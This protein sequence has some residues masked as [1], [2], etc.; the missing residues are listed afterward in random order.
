[1][2]NSNPYLHQIEN[3]LPRLLALYDENSIS[4]TLGLGDRFF[5]AWKLTD[6]G[7][8]TFQG[9]VHGL[10]RLIV[11]D[12]LPFGIDQK[13]ILERIVRMVKAIKSIQ[14]NN[15]SLSEA[16]PYESSFCVTALVAYDLL[17]AVEVLEG[18]ISSDERAE[19]LSAASPLIKF[20]LHHDEHHGLISNHL[21]TAASALYK[22]H[23]LT[24]E[25]SCDRGKVFLDRILA[26]QSDEGWYKEY[27]GADP[28]YQSLCTYYL[29]DLH[30]LRPDLGLKDSLS[31]SVRFL[32]NFAH[33]DGSFGGVY[34]SRSTRF[35]YPAGL[36]LLRDEIPEAG[37][38]ADFMRESILSRS[39]VALDTMD[40]PNLIPMFN[41]YCLAAEVFTESPKS[42]PALPCHNEELNV[43]VF[44]KAGLVVHG[45]T[46]AYTVISTNKGGVCYHFP[47]ESQRSSVK[48]MG[49]VY[50]D[51]KNR[52]FS[53]QA[54]QQKNSIKIEGETIEIWAQLVQ[55]N[56]S[57]PDPLKFIVLRVL[58]LT[59]LRNS[60]LN[61]LIKKMLV[62]LLINRKRHGKVVNHRK[63]NLGRNFMIADEIVGAPAGWSQEEQIG[64]FMASHMASQGYW[65]KQDD[66]K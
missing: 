33:P 15:G 52:R 53:T 17:S 6:F 29:A 4:P 3:V 10:A 14:D 11:N 34:G 32:W 39:T 60:V 50:R 7:N 41:S 58:T 62:W 8:A 28:G 40:D 22:H 49:A 64:P 51:K 38:L 31:K 27:E 61:K 54:F 46:E 24:N 55:P 56:Q 5:W 42:I 26:H 37:A 66:S 59:L 21:A 23:A 16:L 9:A 35:Y 44:P 18:I 45:D 48:N 2:N 65:Q 36:E 25:N 57:L 1:L 47:R 19:M 12:S 63:I 13:S 20:L 30:R 43:L